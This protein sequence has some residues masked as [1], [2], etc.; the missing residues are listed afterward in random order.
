MK[1][2]C[3][4]VPI[5]ISDMYCQNALWLGFL[6]ATNQRILTPRFWQSSTR[7]KFKTKVTRLILETLKT[8]PFSAIATSTW[9][10]RRFNDGHYCD[11]D[12]E[13]NNLRSQMQKY[14]DNS[15]QMVEEEDQI[16]QKWQKNPSLN[17][18]ISHTRNMRILQRG[19]WPLRNKTK[20][21]HLQR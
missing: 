15:Y 12:L 13:I 11:I 18:H 19:T 5:W 16:Q 10:Q 2:T 6:R 17:K 21:P 8:I 3:R 14:S 4:S 9:K 1:A 20:Q 7:A